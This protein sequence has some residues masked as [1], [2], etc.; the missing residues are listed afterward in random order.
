VAGLRILSGPISDVDESSALN[1]DYQ[2]T[3]IYSCSWGPPDNGEAME[4]PNYVIQKAVL[5]GINN[6]RGGLGSIF[7]FASGYGAHHGDQCNFDGYTNSIYS[8]TVSAVDYKGLHPYYSE[9]CAANLVVAYSSGSG[10]RITTTDKGTDQCTNSHGGT[11]A[12]APNVVGVIALALEIRPD[13]SW[14]DIQYIC[15]VS[16]RMINAEDPDWE[17]TA[18]GRRYSYKYGYGAVDA[19]AFVNVAKDWKAVKNQT[20]FE[21]PGV[22]LANGTMD[23]EENIMKGGLPIVPGGVNSTFLVTE[24]M[25]KAHNFELLEHL[26]V[27]VWI[28]HSRR[29]DVE[30]E[31]V[32]PKGVKSVLG[33]SRARD[34]SDTGYPGW[35]F[36]TVK[37]WGEDPV[38]QWTIRVSDQNSKNE[39]GRF[40]GWSMI[41]WGSAIDSAKTEKYELALLDDT[42]P[43]VPEDDKEYEGDE[44]EDE[45]PSETSSAPSATKSHSKPTAHLPGDHG[46][47]EGEN[48]KLAFPG[49]EPTPDEGWFSDM[50][51]LVSGR[52]WFFGAVGAVALF[53]IGAGVFFWKRRQARMAEYASIPEGEDMPMMAVG[54]GGR[55]NSGA[56]RTK[57]LY[58]AFGEVSDEDDGVGGSNLR[59]VRSEGRS[60][61][62]RLGFHSAFLD[63]DDPLSTA[64]PT[65]GYRDDP[66]E[67]ERQPEPV[68]RRLVNE[69]EVSPNGSGDGSWEDASTTK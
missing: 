50:A 26:N 56:P 28:A 67:P 9:S 32:S 55:T 64:A 45:D 31:I 2:N 8:V 33:G 63:D 47:Q 34:D 60:P 14:R 15:I 19:Y 42:F 35:K 39:S 57:E 13:L 49:Q 40:L 36:M 38:G 17:T 68:E 48:D 16:A 30:V 52:K 7:V 65:T 23:D 6:G 3:S 18:T 1:Y 46:D 61:Q 12:A 54:A 58:D 10:K 43:P 5:N 24:H 4:G 62:E 66:D 29:G 51:D 44:D 69:R 21:T 25:K 59:G 11:S 22:Q 53:G 37:H 27:K 20:W 41:F